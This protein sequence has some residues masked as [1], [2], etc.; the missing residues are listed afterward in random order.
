MNWWGIGCLSSLSSGYWRHF[1]R[2]S[3]TLHWGVCCSHGG[4]AQIQVV[5]STTK[6]SAVGS[7]GALAP[8]HPRGIT[9]VPTQSLQGCREPTISNNFISANKVIPG[10]ALQFYSIG[11][12][13]GWWLRSC[14]RHLLF[15][16]ALQ[17]PSPQ[18]GNWNAAL[19]QRK[20]LLGGQIQKG[21][22]CW[23]RWRSGGW[24][25]DHAWRERTILIK[26]A[27]APSSFFSFRALSKVVQ[28][29]GW[30]L[31]QHPDMGLLLQALGEGDAL[32]EEVVPV[33]SEGA[34]CCWVMGVGRVVYWDKTIIHGLCWLEVLGL[35]TCSSLEDDLYWELGIG[36]AKLQGEPPPTQRPMFCVAQ[37]FWNKRSRRNTVE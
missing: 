35:S 28:K 16:P 29:D 18:V 8:K 37:N 17:S 13:F 4:E 11:A 22:S 10:L 7:S 30:V 24:P 21:G 2:L 23:W 34:L 5:R 25:R 14:V 9:E 27:T 32:V 26:T 3:P 12:S 15:P 20:R 36:P 1:R 31:V 33:R 19:G 6:A